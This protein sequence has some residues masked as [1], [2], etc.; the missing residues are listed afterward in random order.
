LPIG[1]P[2]QNANKE[3]GEGEGLSQP[4][5][6]YTVLAVDNEPGILDLYRK[7][8]E[9]EGYTVVTI[10]DERELLTAIEEHHPHVLLMEVSLKH[11]P[12]MSL[13]RA[14]KR[15]VLTR[16]IPMIVCTLNGDENDLFQAGVEVVLRKPIV[17]DDLVEAVN[18][19][20]QIRKKVTPS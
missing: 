10:S 7:Y 9:P 14:L 17:R 19:L 18:N 8:L 1:G 5:K 11:V 20:V 6:G 15:N 16:D 2:E 12:G 3:G 13:V 4:G